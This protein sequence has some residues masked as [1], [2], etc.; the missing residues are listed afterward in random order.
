MFLTPAARALAAD[1]RARLDLA[2]RAVFDKHRDGVEQLIDTRMLAER[3]PGVVANAKGVPARA[4]VGEDVMTLVCRA[5]APVTGAG[6]YYIVPRLGSFFDGEIVS[7]K[8]ASHGSPHLYDRTVSMLVRAPGLI[9]A[10]II[11]D[12]PV[13]FSAF[14]ALEAAFV[15]LDARAPRD[16]LGAHVA[17]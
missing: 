8:G 12:D 2:V 11:I 9:D 15:G 4:R 16:I 5:W 17:R 7:R 14:A 1:R 10:G 3:C 13:D 6:D